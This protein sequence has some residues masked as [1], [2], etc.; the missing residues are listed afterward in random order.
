M[1]QTYH[2]NFELKRPKPTFALNRQ[3]PQ[4]RGL[5]FWAPLWAADVSDYAGNG[6]N[7][8]A[9]ISLAYDIK[10]GAQPAPEFGFVPKGDGTGN[11][12]IKTA[13]GLGTLG[14]PLS[15]SMW[16]NGNS[17]TNP[18]HIF[19]IGTGSA[20]TNFGIR[21]SGADVGLTATKGSTGS[22]LLNSTSTKTVGWHHGVYTFDGTNNTFYF[23]GVADGTNATAPDSGTIT[24]IGLLVNSHDSFPEIAGAFWVADLRIYSRVL[25]AE[26]VARMYRHGSRWDL[27]HTGR[28]T[29]RTI[30]AQ[31]VQ[32]VQFVPRTAPPVFRPR[33]ILTPWRLN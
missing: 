16:F 29:L 31:A 13:A 27:Y 32:N 19:T 2:P 33:Q 10:F 21:N 9:A 22:V 1:I 23:D 18:S 5:I 4:A 15:M 26:D 20:G 28:P 25:T 30:Q 17:T 3:S 7:S 12:V 8:L 24:R 6:K 14:G 11:A